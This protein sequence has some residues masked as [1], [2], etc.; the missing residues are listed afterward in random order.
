MYVKKRERSE[1]EVSGGGLVANSSLFPYLYI[2]IAPA[3]PLPSHQG[4]G[5][6]YNVRR[7]IIPNAGNAVCIEDGPCQRLY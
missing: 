7:I 5:V 6:I 2:L 3:R 1:D 4:D